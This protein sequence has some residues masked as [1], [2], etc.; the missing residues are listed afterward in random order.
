MNRKFKGTGLGLPL[1]KS[2]VEMH[3]GKLLLESE[4]GVGT[5]VSVI[6]PAE[7][8][9]ATGDTAAVPLEPHKAALAS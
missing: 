5:T 8:F 6:L 9:V 1:A 4:L 7:C 3:G 2:L